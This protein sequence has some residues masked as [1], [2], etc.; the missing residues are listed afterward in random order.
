MI[1]SVLILRTALIDIKQSFLWTGIGFT[2]ILISLMIEFNSIFKSITIWMF[3]VIVTI[4]LLY[5]WNIFCTWVLVLIRGL[6]S[7]GFA[8]LTMSLPTAALMLCEVSFI[9][10][11]YYHNCRGFL[12][13]TLLL[14]SI[15]CFDHRVQFQ[16]HYSLNWGTEAIFVCPPFVYTEH[17]KECSIYPFIELFSSDLRW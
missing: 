11:K 1:L 14:G 4:F 12:W 8:L 6:T 3:Y 16:G 17:V 10:D 2:F 5:F 15:I 9:I 7:V 13:S